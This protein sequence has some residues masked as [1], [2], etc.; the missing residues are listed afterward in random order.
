MPRARRAL[1]VAV[2]FRP[3][4]ADAAALPGSPSVGAASGWPAARIGSVLL[5]VSLVLAGLWISLHYSFANW[6]TDPDAADPVMLWQQIRLHGLPRVEQWP[7]LFAHWHH[8][9]EQWG[10]TTD[11]WLLSL[12][13]F[14]FLLYALFGTSPLVVIGSGWLIFIGCCALSVLIARRVCATVPAAVLGAV[15]LFANR[16]ASG[17]VG[18][19]TYSISHG[20]SMLWGL[21][22][23]LFAL[24]WIATW[25]WRWLLACDG[26]LFIGAVSDPWTDA[27]FT[28]PLLMASLLLLACE[29]PGCSRR[30][31]GW[32]ALHLA[33]LLLLVQTRLFGRLWFFPAAGFQLASLTK[34]LGNL[35]WLVR[36]LGVLFN[37]L[38]GVGLPYAGP[39]S[40][41]INPGVGHPYGVPLPDWALVIDCALLAAVL[42]YALV[43]VIRGFDRMQAERRFLTAAVFFSIGAVGAAFLASSLTNSGNI[44]AGR[45][46]VN[47][48]F[49]VPLLIVIVATGPGPRQRWHAR[50]PLAIGGGLFVVA[51]IMSNPQAWMAGRPVVRTAGVPDFVRF[52]EQNGLTYGYGPYWGSAANAVSWVS[53]GRVRIRPVQRDRAS[54]RIVPYPVETAPAWYAPGDVPPGQTD[55]FLAVGPDSMLCV[56]PAVCVARAQRY[57]GPARRVLDFRGM[58]VLVWNHPILTR[59]PDSRMA[60]NLPP[61]PAGRW[62][63]FGIGGAGQPLLRDGW[64]YPESFGTWTDGV[65]AALLLHLPAGWRGPVRLELTAIG[66][67]PLHGTTQRV[68]LRANGR[69]IGA[70]D[71]RSGVPGAYHVTI[72]FADLRDGAAVLTLDV[73]DAVS[74]RATVGGPDRRRLGVYL[75]RMRVLPPD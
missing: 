45:F 72:P 75:T 56:R 40:P 9:L 12:I 3:S 65:E 73:P 29:R 20:I 62:L 43:W 25:R 49:F 39:M 48:Y 44:N 27:A 55:F 61:L 13:P 24:R 63:G 33:V 54:G 30:A 17:G 28:L 46:L 15:L 26:A 31:T 66:F 57:F 23:V 4:P 37:V 36:S 14:D 19:L 34:M 68:R 41:W 7:A 6:S 58:P 71:V 16:S 74:P 70:L 69:A 42:G 50:V 8:A 67:A 32:L 5:L 21:G 59:P 38:P 64:S 52:L 10:Y 60:L 1:P 2:T 11:N 47:F 18:Y 35:S 22:A 53:D 51:G